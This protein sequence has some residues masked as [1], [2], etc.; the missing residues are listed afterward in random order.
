VAGV[1][2]RVVIVYNKFPVIAAGLRGKVALAVRKTA[3]D[4]EA[5]A[6][7]A[8]PVDTGNL[9]NSILAENTGPGSARV[10]VGAEYGIYQEFGTNRMGAQPFFFQAVHN[11]EQAF[12]NALSSMISSGTT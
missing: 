5:S 12:V 1:N 2:T 3:L 10:T 6:K 8:A 4:I 7:A 11:A 9:Q